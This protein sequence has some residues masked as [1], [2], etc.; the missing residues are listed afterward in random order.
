MFINTT[1]ETTIHFTLFRK[2]LIKYLSAVPLQD[3]EGYKEAN[4]RSPQ[5]QRLRIRIIMI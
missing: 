2:L 1:S 4:V 5:S 3:R